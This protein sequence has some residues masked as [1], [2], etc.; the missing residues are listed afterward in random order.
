[1]HFTNELH[2]LSDICCRTLVVPASHSCVSRV[3]W[4]RGGSRLVGVY[5][6]S[7]VPLSGGVSIQFARRG[8]LVHDRPA[9]IKPLCKA[10]R[11]ILSIEL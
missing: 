7:F 2:P 3:G 1:M 4:D 5:I 9:A 11:L 8:R 10:I 6:A